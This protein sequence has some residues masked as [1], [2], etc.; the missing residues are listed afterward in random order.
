MTNFFFKLRELG[1]NIL[2]MKRAKLGSHGSSIITSKTKITLRD[3]S[4]PIS[5]LLY[6]RIAFWRSL[7]ICILFLFELFW[8]LNVRKRTC[9]VY[10]PV[11]WLKHHLLPVPFASILG[12][13][14]HIVDTYIIARKDWS[15]NTSNAFKTW[16][17]YVWM[18]LTSSRTHWSKQIKNSVPLLHF[19]MFRGIV[20]GELSVLRMIRFIRNTHLCGCVLDWV[21]TIVAGLTIYCCLNLW[22]QTWSH[23]SF[24]TRSISLETPIDPKLLVFLLC[25]IVNCTWLHVWP[26]I[27]RVFVVEDNHL[28]G[29]Y[30][31][32][33]IVRCAC[34]RFI[35]TDSQIVFLV[36]QKLHRP[37]QWRGVR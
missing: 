6:T 29:C 25:V 17:S 7:F 30:F 10:N 27:H 18:P 1:T 20:W 26:D 28:F 8:H 31:C 12:K 2:T 4:I 36:C 34:F 23:C 5:F 9:W 22:I 21:L 11:I 16:Y 3:E 35:C 33:V 24:V 37:V 32:M 14:P 13:R 15:I 19:C